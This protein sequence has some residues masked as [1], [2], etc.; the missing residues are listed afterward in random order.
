MLCSHLEVEEGRFTGR[1]S[2]LCYG[3]EKV[4]VA[5]EWASEEGVDLARSSFYSDSVS[6]LPMLERVGDPRV[7]NPDPRL[8]VRAALNRW[9]VEHWR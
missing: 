7:V 6:D 4:R 1:C 5:Q 3:P 9:P 8:R 2:L